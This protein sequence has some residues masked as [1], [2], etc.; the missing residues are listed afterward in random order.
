M[1]LADDVREPC[2]TQPVSERA[3]R[4]ARQAC[5][6]EET[7]HSPSPSDL[8]AEQSAVSIYGEGPVIGALG[9]NLRKNL[10][11]VDRLAVDVDND[12]ALAEA[13]TPADAVARIDDGDAALHILQ[14][15]LFA[16]CRRKVDDCEAG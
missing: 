13:H 9:E 10:H 12:V 14:P 11:A 15:Q 1:I 8:Q 2:R 3:R 4:L 6:L 16:H 5:C 7:R